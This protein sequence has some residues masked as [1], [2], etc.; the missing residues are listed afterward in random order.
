[1]AA[2]IYEVASLRFIDWGAR[3]FKPNPNR[4]FNSDRGLVPFRQDPIF[5]PARNG[6][7]NLVIIVF[8]L[9]GYALSSVVSVE[10]YSVVE[11]KI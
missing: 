11:T 7:H 10:I 1:M 3:V 2:L 8:N 9:L 6:I 4:D 5:T